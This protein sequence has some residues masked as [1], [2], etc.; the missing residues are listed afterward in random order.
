MTDAIHEGVTVEALQAL[1]SEQSAFTRAF[2]FQVR[3]IEPGLCH[4]LVPFNPLFERPGGILSGQVYMT[5][6]DVA[7]W[8]AIKTLKG[9][10]DTSVTVNMSTSFVRSARREPVVCTARVLRLG[11][12]ISHGSA[13]C[14][15]EAGALLTHHSLT[16][17]RPEPRGPAGSA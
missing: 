17:M 10:H 14:F 4:L 12:R 2:G 8:L 11:A 6:A 15:S 1:L 7:M 5:A 3:A 13:E 16:Y 9:L